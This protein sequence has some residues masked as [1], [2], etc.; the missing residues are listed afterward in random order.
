MTTLPTAE[1][2]THTE[3]PWHAVAHDAPDRR[4]FTEVC[5]VYGAGVP[6]SV[7]PQTGSDR[8]YVIGAE[9]KANV[10]LIAATP[11]LLAVAKM[12]ERIP[13]SVPRYI[14]EAARAAILKAEGSL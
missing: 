5:M 11:D 9:A 4:D 6:M 8:S 2:T 3:G 12:I 1:R 14:V 13:M 7:G 10:N